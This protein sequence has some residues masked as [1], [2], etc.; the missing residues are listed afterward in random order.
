MRPM[1]DTTDYPPD[2]M[3]EITWMDFMKDAR[4]AIGD[5]PETER[6]IDA[7][8]GIRAPIGDDSAW[9]ALLETMTETFEKMR[10]RP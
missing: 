6:L 10:P 4:R 2:A 7:M 1:A 3:A 9:V 8:G 5:G